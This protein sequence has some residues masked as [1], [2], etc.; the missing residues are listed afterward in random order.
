[1]P[2]RCGA[3]AA[4]FSRARSLSGRN[5]LSC[6]SHSA[7]SVSIADA[8]ARASS[9]GVRTVILVPMERNV[10]KA[11]LGRSVMASMD[12]RSRLSAGSEPI[13][14]HCPALAAD[15]RRTGL[16]RPAWK[17][18]HRCFGRRLGA[19]LPRSRRRP[20]RSATIV[21][22]RRPRSVQQWT[23]LAAEVVHS[24][25]SV[26]DLDREVCSR[27]WAQDARRFLED[28]GNNVLLPSPSGSDG[29]WKWADEATEDLAQDARI[30][31]S[32]R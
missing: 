30:P 16:P 10:W 31:V 1:V 24:C 4:A 11:T 20:H 23:P 15:Y 3:P 2:T 12:V 18:I 32:G 5:R 27:P 21:R 7:K 14:C 22:G 8:S 25:G 9:R 13:R 29:R 28:G 17:G 19:R 26:A 6:P